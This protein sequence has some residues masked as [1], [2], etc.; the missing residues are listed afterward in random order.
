MAETSFDK[1]ISMGVKHKL[2][3]SPQK[4]PGRNGIIPAEILPGLGKEMKGKMKAGC[5][6]SWILQDW[7]ILL[8]GCKCSHAFSKKG[9]NDPKGDSEIIRAAPSSVSKGGATTVVSMG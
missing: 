9:N 3:Q 8:F 1:E 5:W 2:N 6:T 7:T 4:K